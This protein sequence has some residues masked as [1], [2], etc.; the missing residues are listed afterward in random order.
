MGIL[1]FFLVLAFFVAS[2]ADG[3]IEEYYEEG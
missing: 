3:Y 2:M 1:I